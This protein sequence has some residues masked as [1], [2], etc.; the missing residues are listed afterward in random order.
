METATGPEPDDQSE[1]RLRRRRGA[2][3][4]RDAVTAERVLKAAVPAGSRFK[5]YEDVS[6]ATEDWP[7]RGA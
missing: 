4:D 5:G 7:H 6:G 1:A 3:R 2:K